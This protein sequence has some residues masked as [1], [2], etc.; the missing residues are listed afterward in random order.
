MAGTRI[1]KGVTIIESRGRVVM[2]AGS[3]ANSGTTFR[4]QGASII[5]GKNVGIGYNCFFVTSYGSHYLGD[6]AMKR[7]KPIV[8]KDNAW[9]GY[10]AMIRG[11]VTIGKFAVV[12]MGAVVLHD[13]PDYHV[14]AGNPAV[15]VGLRPDY[16]QV[17]EAERT[18]SIPK[19]SRN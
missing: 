3:G 13:V 2:G 11:G 12:G 14:A 19:V 1:E 8:V 9:I 15:D 10:G 6:E 5:I 16:E 4:A 7:K 18:G 17:L